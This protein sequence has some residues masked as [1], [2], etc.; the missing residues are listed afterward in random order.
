MLTRILPFL[1]WP[2]PTPESL[3]ADLIAGATVALV[4]IPQALAYAQLAG[5]PAYYGL[6][7]ALLPC[8]V[9]ALFGSSAQLSTGPVAL[10]S[11]LTAASVAPLAQTGSGHYVAYVVVLALLSGAL[12]LAFG[13]MRLGVL[14]N[15]LSH[16]VLMGFLNAAAIL[17]T[18]SQVPELLGFSLRQGDHFLLDMWQ[19]LHDSP[20]I[21]Y[22]SLA[23]GVCALA[24][25]LAFRR[26]VPK[27]P[28]VLLA[29][30]LLTWVSY[31]I[32]FA[33]HGGRVVGAI[34]QGLPRP[35][36]PEI[37][38]PIVRDLLPAAFVIA[39]ISFM[40][41]ASSC[42][43]I[44]AKTRAVWDENREL[45]GQGLAKI[46]AAAS[47]TMPVSG[48]FSR[49]AL[50][51]ASGARTGLASVACAVFVLLTIAFLTPYLYHLPKSVLAAIV[52]LALFGLINLRSFAKAWRASRD[53]GIAAAATFVATL[54][55]APNIQNGILT[56]IILSLALHLYRGMRPRIVTAGLHPDGT[57]RDAAR[58]GLPP[59]HPRV[60]II[61]IDASLTF[62]TASHFEEA[63]L[64]VERDSPRVQFM[65]IAAGG[66]NELDATG[67]ELLRNLALRLKENGITL[68][69]S[70]AKKQVLEVMERTGLA[71][72]LGA[73]NIYPT[74]AAA[75]AGLRARCSEPDSAQ[76]VAREPL[77][78][79]R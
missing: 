13:L 40:E 73:E 17:I 56:G 34:P 31:A 49:S 50:N 22:L 61:R 43:V 36:M 18:L 44:A 24:L 79:R 75:V 46:A 39:L 65:L 9:G 51:L 26:F 53:D 4:G 59:I 3:R 60:R 28:G 29:V 15:L 12:Q 52:M 45:V 58:F 27:A 69:L 71:G 32:G 2:R 55:F 68:A 48:S 1:A 41:A 6:Y 66:M 63:V 30:A 8:I 25:L 77:A 33:E 16:P 37:E 72:L 67:V 64:K 62:V 76:D 42:K 74:D 11:L 19:G 38:W 21:H 10:T 20:D 14:L 57:L 54:V 23:L 5:I 35:V 47:G 78:S 70:A 7:A